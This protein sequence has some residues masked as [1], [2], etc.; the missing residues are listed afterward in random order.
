MRET[1]V[2]VLLCRI[3]HYKIQKQMVVRERY[4][5]KLKRAKKPQASA[6]SEISPKGVPYVY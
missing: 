6:D 3:E 1:E 4:R 5:K 2:E